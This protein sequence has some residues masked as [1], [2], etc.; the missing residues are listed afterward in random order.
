MIIPLTSTT[1]SKKRMLFTAKKGVGNGLMQFNTIILEEIALLSKIL[2]L[3]KS[4]NSVQLQILT[5]IFCN[6]QGDPKIHRGTPRA[7]SSRAAR[8]VEVPAFSAASGRASDPTGQPRDGHTER[9][10]TACPGHRWG[11]ENCTP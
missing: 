11:V 9:G 3:P 7:E 8:E 6:K 4:V 10:A 1:Q 5:R 2:T